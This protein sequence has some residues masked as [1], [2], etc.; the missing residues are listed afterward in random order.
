MIKTI[1]WATDLGAY[2]PVI[3][4]HAVAMATQHDA[5]IVV[6]HAVEPLSTMADAVVRAFLPNETQLALEHGGKENIMRCIRDS[7]IQNLEDDFVDGNDGLG[8][9]RDV[10]VREGRPV[11]VILTEAHRCH[12]DLIILGSHSRPT[13]NA[14]P[15]GS[16][17]AKVLQLAP[18]PVY[19]VP[20]MRSK[21]TV[22]KSR[23]G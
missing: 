11:D 5:S 1:L 10:L 15:L 20:M 9:I 22:R 16:V 14:T 7:L 21:A 13:E 12:A 3:L 2:T 18:V 19:M 4:Q 17:A 6:V 23:A 8:K